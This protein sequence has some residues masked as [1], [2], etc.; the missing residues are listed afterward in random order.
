M[1]D[2]LDKNLYDDIALYIKKN[3]I[4]RGYK[5]PN[6][7]VSK[8]DSIG[9]LKKMPRGNLKP[10]EVSNKKDT[11]SKELMQ[12]R[13]TDSVLD[14]KFY[15]YFNNDIV[16]LANLSGVEFNRL[17]EISDMKSIPTKD[18]VIRLVFGLKLNLNSSLEFVS[19]SGYKLSNL[20]KKDV[21]IKYFIENEIYDIDALKMVLVDYGFEFE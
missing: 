20:K 15:S 7:I 4:E 1:S 14:S 8:N 17:K 2:S 5:T 9:R 18:E 16:E 13:N 21:I 6:D 12:E 19:L 3:Y 10:M 11:Y